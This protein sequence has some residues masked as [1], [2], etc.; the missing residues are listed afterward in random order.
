MPLFAHEKDLTVYDP[1]PA[2]DLNG[3]L[4]RYN[5]VA[6]FGWMSDGH[7]FKQVPDGTQHGATDNGDGTYTNPPPPP[8]RTQ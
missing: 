5:S 8:P 3:Y 2:A 1:Q 4:L 6:V 7:T